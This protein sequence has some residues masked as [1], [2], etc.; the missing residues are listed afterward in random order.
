MAQVSKVD[1]FCARVRQ[2]CDMEAQGRQQPGFR[3]FELQCNA[4]MILQNH[5]CQGD[6]YLQAAESRPEKIDVGIKEVGTRRFLRRK[7][8]STYCQPVSQMTMSFADKGR[9]A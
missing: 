7:I 9:E 5:D 6:S 2:S 4:R 8:L 3:C 1:C